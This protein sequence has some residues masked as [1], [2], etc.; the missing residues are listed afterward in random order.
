MQRFPNQAPVWKTVAGRTVAFVFLASVVLV[1]GSLDRRIAN[2][3]TRMPLPRL[4]SSVN[5][6]F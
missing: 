6:P 1:A 2:A 3:G 5:S 4:R